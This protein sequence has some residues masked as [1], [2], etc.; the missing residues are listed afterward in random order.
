MRSIS[1]SPVSM[2]LGSRF[3]RKPRALHG[4]SRCGGWC[5]QGGSG[6]GQGSGGQ[7]GSGEWHGGFSGGGHGGF[8]G[9][10]QGGEPVWAA[11][12][13]CVAPVVW[14]GRPRG[15]GFRQAAALIRAVALGNVTV[16]HGVHL[17]D[18]IWGP[19][20]LQGVPC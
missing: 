6:C 20:L 19:R 17:P 9:G 12:A 4:S 16:I 2:F 5:S 14:A 11:L 15:T 8:S 10:G 7:G 3:C 1:R 13:V 18:R